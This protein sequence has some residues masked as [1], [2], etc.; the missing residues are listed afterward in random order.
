MSIKVYYSFVLYCFFNRRCSR[1]CRF[2]IRIRDETIFAQWQRISLPNLFFALYLWA[3]KINC[4]GIQRLLGISKRTAINLSQILR[5]CCTNSLRRNPIQIGG[6]GQNFVVQI[7]ES[8]LHHRQRVCYHFS[9]L[10]NQFDC[11]NVSDYYTIYMFSGF[12]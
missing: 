7:D 8:Q 1:P 11:Y 5:E 9:C 4:V 6:N 2:T 10:K 12:G 3:N